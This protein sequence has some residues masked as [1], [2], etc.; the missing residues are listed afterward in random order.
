LGFQRFYGFF[1]F[2]NPTFQVC[3]ALLAVVVSFPALAG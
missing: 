2:C 1:P 3:K